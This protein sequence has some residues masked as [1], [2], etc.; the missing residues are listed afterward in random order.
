MFDAN[1]MN[2][3][4]A[5]LGEAFASFKETITIFKTPL[6]TI[7]ST[8]SSS[9]N[10]AFG[11]EQPSVSIS[12]VVQSGSFYATVEYADTREDQRLNFPDQN[13]PVK[14][15]QG[16]V[17]ISI[18]GTSGAD[19]LRKAEVIKIDGRD[20]NRQSDVLPRGLFSRNY[21]DCWLQK[22]DNGSI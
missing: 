10:F 22:I 16:W 21:Y 20:F 14:Q 2:E 4:E 5:L 18:S 13:V 8:S 17:R 15:N 7:L 9:F 19:F 1:E 11:M 12:E 3:A 6:K